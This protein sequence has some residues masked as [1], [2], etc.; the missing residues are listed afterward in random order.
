MNKFILL[1]LFSSSF[2]IA[3]DVSKN[4]S[5]QVSDGLTPIANVS[6]SVENQ[7]ESIFTNNE[8]KYNLKANVGAVIT[9]SNQGMKTIRI[10][11]EDVTRVLNVTMVPD[12][13]ELDEVVVVGSNRKSQSDL[14]LEYPTNQ[15]LIR[16]AFG[17]LNAETAAGNIRFLYE[18]EINSVAICILDLLRNEFSGVRVEGT[19]L[20]AFGPGAGTST[21][22]T[23]ITGQRSNDPGV[24]GLS[25]AGTGVS[26]GLNSGKVFIRGGN[27]LFNPRAAIFDVDGQIFND[28]PVWLEVKNIKRLAILSNFATSTQYGSA[29][30]GGVV[31]INTVSGSPKSDKVFDKARLR[32]NFVSGTILSAEGL[33]HN[34][35]TYFQE[36]DASNSLTE[37]KKVYNKYAKQ[38]SSLPY[39]S[40]DM[41][42]YFK[43][44]WNEDSFADDIVEA[45]KFVFQD[46]PVLLKALAYQYQEQGEYEKANLIYKEVLKLRPSYAQ[47]YLDLANSYRELR[48]STQAAAIYTRYNHLV[49]NDL[50]KADS[51]SFGPI[52]EREYNNF[53]FLNKTSIIKGE[54]VNDLYIAEEEFNGT[55]L[56]FEW[57]DSEAEFD[58]QFVN[59][60]NQYYIWKHSLAD[61]AE[62][63][64]REK[65]YGFNTKE[66]LLDYSLPGTWSVNVNYSGNKSLS[67]TY[68]KATVYHNYGTKAQRKEIKVFKLSL[69]NVNQELFKIQSS[70]RIASN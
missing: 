70:A 17:Y 1:F 10:K 58:L 53:L 57:N 66:Y 29:G 56:V 8:G 20:G 46:N 41:Q 12:I 50:V 55:R 61:N 59:P 67:P 43:E 14:A 37:A 62:T 54:G 48:N 21:Q 11:V 2:C 36:I 19:C 5:G 60:G 65:D 7:S 3:Q 15:N 39:F 26:S 16:T 32:N 31:V 64:Y 9:Y 45:N 30:A 35:P 47:S 69:K 24:V 51:L 40:L 38:Y 68:L 18:D 52:L 63:I 44:K 27:S 6:I 49:E 28:A 25:N 4:I 42:K 22:L 33:K 34:M 13:E 23:N